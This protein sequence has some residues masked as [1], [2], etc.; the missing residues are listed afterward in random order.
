MK[1]FFFLLEKKNSEQQWGEYDPVYHQEFIKTTAK[2]GGNA[3]VS[4]KVNKCSAI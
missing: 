4:M 1:K 2:H 3:E